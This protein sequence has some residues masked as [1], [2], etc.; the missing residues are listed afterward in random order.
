MSVIYMQLS[1]M[2]IEWRSRLYFRRL[3]DRLN[4]MF[5]ESQLAEA[6]GD[7]GTRCAGP[8]AMAVGTPQSDVA[9][10]LLVPRCRED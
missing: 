8:V 5:D 2:S 9:W 3:P 4:P 1:S 10:V 7:G 6:R